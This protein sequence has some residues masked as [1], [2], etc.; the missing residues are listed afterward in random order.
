MLC[1]LKWLMRLTIQPCWRTHSSSCIPH[2]WN[3]FQIR[4]AIWDI[5][6]FFSLCAS[7]TAPCHY[8]S[9]FKRYI[10]ISWWI[11][12]SWWSSVSP[13]LIWSHLS[14]IMQWFESYGPANWKNRGRCCW[15]KTLCR[16]GD[17]FDDNAYV[18]APNLF[19]I[20]PFLEEIFLS[21]AQHN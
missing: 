19:N 7:V 21:T 14:K 1:Q 20:F 4:Q 5:G 12:T 8:P 13:S 17:D 16:S 9:I 3:V 10:Y 11:L 6:V 18:N 15:Q 2:N